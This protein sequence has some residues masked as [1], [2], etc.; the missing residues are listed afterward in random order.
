LDLSE[1][2]ARFQASD[3]QRQDAYD[4]SRNFQR[5]LVEAQIDLEQNKATASEWIRTLQRALE[6]AVGNGTP[7]PT[8]RAPRLANLNQRVEDLCRL[9]AMHHFLEHGKLL[10]PSAC[11]FSD[12]LRATDE[13]YLAGA[14]MGVAQDL[15]RYAMG[16]ATAR[17]AAS[18]QQARDLVHEILEYLLKFDFRNGFLRRK[19]DGTKYALKVRQTTTKLQNANPTSIGTTQANGASLDPCGYRGENNLVMADS[20]ICSH[21]IWITL[22]FQSV[23][24]F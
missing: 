5:A 14:C 8:G 16:R 2:A 21:Q 6:E 18:V 20:S 15:S 23:T 7:D 13:E 11:A 24:F 9:A 4:K 12:T 19:Y 3:E 10:P 22:R 1:L 17:D